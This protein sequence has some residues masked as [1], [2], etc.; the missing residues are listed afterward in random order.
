MFASCCLL[1]IP[2]VNPLQKLS[3]LKLVIILMHYCKLFTF[4][5]KL[6]GHNTLKLTPAVHITVSVMAKLNTNICT[7]LHCIGMEGY[8]YK[9]AHIF[10]AAFLVVLP[11]AMSKSY[12][13]L[14][15]C[16]STSVRCF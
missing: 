4:S 6:S 15:L 13:F 3:F 9:T 11:L 8:S 7:N 2:A 16:T 1:V 10:K 5:M 12:I 14:V